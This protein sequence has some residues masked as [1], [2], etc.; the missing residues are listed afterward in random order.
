M[1][2]LDVSYQWCIFQAATCGADDVRKS[3]MGCFD[4]NDGPYNVPPWLG[5]HTL[6]ACLNT[7]G[8]T[9]EQCAL[10][11]AQ[12]GYEVYSIQAS[13]YCCMGPLTDAVQMK[14]KYDDSECTTIPCY[15]GVGCINLVHKVYVVGASRRRLLTACISLKL[16]RRGPNKVHSVN[17]VYGL[18]WGWV[19]TVCQ[20]AKP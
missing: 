19:H 13:G 8:F 2:S 12:A 6:P 4:D 1:D 20:T 15:N 18:T 9:L 16:T 11:A 14:T 10:A 3:Y 17:Y 5:S 7:N